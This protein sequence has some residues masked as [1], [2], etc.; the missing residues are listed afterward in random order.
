M[1]KVVRPDGNHPQGKPRLPQRS[2][3]CNDAWDVISPMRVAAS[4]T[5]HDILLRVRHSTCRRRFLLAG[6][7]SGID[8]FPALLAF[9]SVKKRCPDRISGVLPKAIG[10]FD[11]IASAKGIGTRR[12]TTFLLQRSE[13]RRCIV[14]GGVMMEVMHCMRP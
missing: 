13:Y 5:Q 9:I 11:W 2:T 3:D 10:L 14:S 12:R 6:Y 1:H 4:E 8:F 7:R